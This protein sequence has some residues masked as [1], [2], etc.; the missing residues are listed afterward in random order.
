VTRD[1]APAPRV[2]DQAL[3]QIDTVLARYKDVPGPLLEVL[4]AVQTAIGYVPPQ[5]I[6]LIADALNLSRAEVHG[7]VTFYHHFRQSPAGRHVIRI[8]QAEACRAMHCEALTAHAKTRLQVGFHETT[9][10]GRYSL[11]P[12]YCL[13]NCAC[14]PALMIDDEIHGRVTEDAF[15]ELVVKSGSES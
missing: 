4:H 15:D 9:A 5:S 2:S 11:E 7:V 1:A 12:V 14:S 13:G 8:C 3:A 10:D 6:G